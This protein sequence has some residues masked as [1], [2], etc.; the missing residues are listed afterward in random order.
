L[1]NSVD[2]RQEESHLVAGV[3][4]HP[5]GRSGPRYNEALL[6]VPTLLDDDDED[7]GSG[8]LKRFVPSSLRCF[9]AG[10]LRNP[11]RDA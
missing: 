2:L 4:K 5:R 3:W 6:R 7:D 8:N 1:P 11:S 9:G 10:S